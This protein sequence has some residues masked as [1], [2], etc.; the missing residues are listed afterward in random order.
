MGGLVNFL[1]LV[2]E[3]YVVWYVRLSLITL[4]SVTNGDK[5]VTLT[6]SGLADFPR[7]AFS[8]TFHSYQTET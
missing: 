7:L 6:V 8:L 5:I 3:C 2:Y 1:P 4:V